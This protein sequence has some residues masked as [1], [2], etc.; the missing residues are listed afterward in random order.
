M[1][2]NSNTGTASEMLVC[3]M[4]MR[5]GLEAYLTMGNKKSVDIRVVQD[6]RAWTI[7]VKAVRGYSSW[8]VNNVVEKSNHFVVLLC[9][10]NHFEDVNE[11]PGVYVVPS[12]EM[13]SI[14]KTYGEQKR[15]FKESLS[16]YHD[17]WDLMPIK[18]T[19][20]SL[21]E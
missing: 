4:L 13:S 2:D 21:S 18:A 5:M 12:G 3:S 7:D 16:K 11:T 17:A 19:P 6:D 9:Y 20:R 15:V 14:I 8:I 1:T 10:N